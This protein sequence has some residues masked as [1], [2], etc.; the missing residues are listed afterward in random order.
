MKKDKKI[1]II[2]ICSILVLLSLLMIF[3][4]NTDKD[5]VIEDNTTTTTTE[6][7]IESKELI[8]D[9]TKISIKLTDEKYF[10][11]ELLIEN[12]DN[13]VIE[14]SIL[15]YDINLV[16]EN[17][18]KVQVENTNLLISIPYVNV[19]NYS[20][21][22]VLYI[23]KNNNILETLNANYENAKIV[24]NVNHLSR[25][26]ILG[27]KD[28]ESPTTTKKTTTK[29]SNKTQSAT[30]KLNKTQS[31]TKKSNTTQSTTKKSNTTQANVKHWTVT[32][33]W[34]YDKEKKIIVENG[35][36]IS[37]IEYEGELASNEVFKYWVVSS[38]REIFDF[39]TKIYKDYYLTPVLGA[40]EVNNAPTNIYFSNKDNIGKWD[41]SNI[42]VTWDKVENAGTYNIYFSETLNG[43]YE[44]IKKRNTNDAAIANSKDGYY[45]IEAS[46]GS[47]G[48]MSEPIYVP[49]VF[50]SNISSSIICDEIYNHL[51]KTT[52]YRNGNL[53]VVNPYNHEIAVLQ[54]KY[55]NGYTPIVHTVKNVG[56]IGSIPFWNSCFKYAPV[57]G[58]YYYYSVIAYK[59]GNNYLIY[60]VD[61]NDI[62]AY[63]ANRIYK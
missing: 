33:A 44:L 61:K 51:D 2:I 41:I 23:D 4:F 11:N 10:N 9:K 38:T 32:F 52:T 20:Q 18:N 31:T 21:F 55:N 26:V 27:I 57:N 29:K 24:F 7:I 15:A 58:Y 36:T 42:E 25:Y 53:E 54:M 17:S 16:D 46:N 22:K 40:K 39:N 3:L 6:I 63:T 19:N 5:E 35:K 60:S 14:N 28:G 59:Q 43:N 1:L 8:D 37:P 30:K 50:T 62:E 47:K 34:G 12:I 56:N 45:K 48:V 49:G 13:I